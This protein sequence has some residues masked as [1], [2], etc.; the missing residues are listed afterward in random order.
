[1]LV[2][3]LARPLLASIFVTGGIDTL[4]GTPARARK[5]APVVEPVANQLGLT[6]EQLVRVDAGVKIVAGLLLATNRLPRL[7]AIVLA[8]SLVPTTVGG[9]RFWEEDD[10]AARRN[11]LLHLQKNAALLGGLLLAAVDTEGKPSLAHRTRDALR[12]TPFS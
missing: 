1:M 12:S 5:A 10:P 9:H 3:R 7:S 11:Q 4:R 2:R 6:P 8:A